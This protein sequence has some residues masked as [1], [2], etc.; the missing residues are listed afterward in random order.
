M[1]EGG[2][3]TILG[4]QRKGGWRFWRDPG[5]G[6]SWMYDDDDEASAE[7]ASE[8]PIRKPRIDY[9]DTL[10]EVLEKINASWPRLRPRQVHP[11]FAADI[12][13]RVTHYF[14]DN[15]D[16]SSSVISRWEEICL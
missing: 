11:M 9:C 1:G 16:P 15:H 7:P 13:R 5:C 14:A 12:L 8:E 4:E 6:D 10:D 3:Y 2:G